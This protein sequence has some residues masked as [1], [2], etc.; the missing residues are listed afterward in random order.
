M[1]KSNPKQT[2]PVL[3]EPPTLDVAGR[4]YR[5]RRLGLTDVF[6][7]SRILGRGVAMLAGKADP[8]PSDVINVLLISL[9]A[10]EEEVLRLIASI[11]HE[12][13]PGDVKRA[14][15]NDPNRFPMASIID[16]LTTLSEH[17]D[18]TGFLTRLQTLQERL[19][20]M[21]TPQPAS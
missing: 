19:P 2:D 13:E 10:N 21:Q 7:V 9:S 12:H 1:P 6:A 3:Y 20:E 5:L 11:I 16:I 8:H 17:Q 14:D 4:T 15:L 18:L